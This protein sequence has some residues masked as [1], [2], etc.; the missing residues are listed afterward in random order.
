MTEAAKQ[1]LAAAEQTVAAAEEKV[2]AAEQMVAAAEQKVEDAREQALSHAGSDLTN[3]ESARGEF[4][5][6][7]EEIE[8]SNKELILARNALSALLY[9]KVFTCTF[10]SFFIARFLVDSS[11]R[12]AILFSLAKA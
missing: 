1:D 12:L 9:P 10:R 6:A 8:S 7:Q 11:H 2:A 4:T 5:I 3:L